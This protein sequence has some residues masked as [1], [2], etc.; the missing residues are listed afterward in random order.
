MKLL[1]KAVARSLL[2]SAVLACGSASAVNLT[3]TH[4]A[5]G[6]YGAPFAV[7]VEKGYFKDAGVDVTG[8]I[9]SK[10]GG[11]TVRNAL[12]ADI[13]YG[14]VA[15]PA[16]IAAIK[17]GVKLTI[18]HGGVV[19]L[20]DNFW[21][22]LKDSPLKSIEDLAGKKLGYSSPKSVTDM[23]STIALSSRKLLDK[24]NRQTVG[25]L[26][27]AYTALREGGVDVI[28]MTEPIYSREKDNLKIVFRSGDEIP[29]MTQTVG[30]V[31]TD[32]LKEHPETIKAIIEGR[33]KGVDYLLAHPEE[34]GDILAR[35]YKMD[36]AIT[37]AAIR[38]IMSAKR[39][40][41]SPGR[42]DYEGMDTMLKGLVLVKAIDEGPFDWKAIVNE[43]LLPADQRSN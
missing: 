24:V 39:V 41:W 36:P 32:Y 27:S 34:G 17:Q 28:Y 16:A 8:F 2:F 15:L 14:E 30:I 23:V 33:R 12:A 43:S 40:Y 9:T 3:V 26:S 25:S 21:V 22:A 42:L 20:A 19:S 18:V 11:T 5:D 13:P 31:R 35:Q 7:A 1:C 10:G 4:W 6:M 37:K 38:N 29:H